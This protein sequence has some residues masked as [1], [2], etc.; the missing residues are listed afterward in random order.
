MD[1]DGVWCRHANSHRIARAHANVFIPS[2]HWRPS[3]GSHE[4]ARTGHWQLS[5]L[6][7]YIVCLCE[8]ATIAVLSNALAGY[9]QR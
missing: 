7:R 9:L 4:T 1:D 5:A 6:V 3:D 8:R 2:Q